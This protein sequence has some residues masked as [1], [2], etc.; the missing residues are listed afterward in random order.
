MQLKTAFS[1]YSNYLLVVAVIF[2]LLCFSFPANRSE[3]DDGYFFAHAISHS[4]YPEL[5]YPRYFLF[6]PF[7]KFCYEL[8]KI[9]YPALD[10]YRMMCMMSSLFAALSIVLLFRILG[11]KLGASRSIAWFTCILL[12]V[13]YAF[14]R[15]AVEAEVYMLSFFVLLLAFD[16]LYPGV[17]QKQ[18]IPFGRI[19]LA[20]AFAALAVMFYKP[21]L[22]IVG[23]AYG[24]PLLVK[25]QWR[26]LLVYGAA[27][28]LLLLMGYYMAYKINPREFASLMS[29]LLGGSSHSK[30]NALLSI[31]VVGSNWASI[32]FVF[33]IPQFA[34]FIAT[35]FPNNI[36]VEEVYAARNLYTLS[37][38]ACCT[39]LALVGLLLWILYKA[40]PKVD[41]KQCWANPFVVWVLAYSIMLMVLEPNAPEAWLMIM[42]PLIVLFGTLP[43]T[44]YQQLFGMRSLWLLAAVLCL[45]NFLGGYLFI[46]SKQGDYLSYQGAWI[47]KHARQKDLVVSMGSGSLIRY[48]KYY[49]T[50]P[51]CVPEQQY[52]SCL[53]Q[54][55]ATLA[56]GGNVYL[57]NDILHPSEAVAFRDK[58]AFDKVVAFVQK[59]SGHIIPVNKGSHTEGIVYQLVSR[60]P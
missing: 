5:L 1:K 33:G 32:N 37:V 56:R 14:W 53:V 18:P 19:L 30:G 34:G 58:P 11:K 45:H 4:T 8:G 2:L 21:N 10:A 35:H 7:M 12:L 16:F 38:I 13:S 46:Q 17:E 51:L 42:P 60:E 28:C 44:A 22:I 43:A 41:W 54:I 29:Y 31:L 36:I 57:L 25:K 27:M 20:A 15:Y 55:D 9:V 59:N 3:N 39:F 24:W 47:L 52:D 23:I 6:L 49:A 50:A 48:L 40:I 26:T